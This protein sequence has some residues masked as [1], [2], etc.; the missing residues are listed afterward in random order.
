MKAY[1]INL[2]KIVLVLESFI[3]FPLTNVISINVGIVGAGSEP[4]LQSNRKCKREIRERD[5]VRKAR[6][7]TPF[8]LGL[9]LMLLFL[10]LKSMKLIDF[11][12][13]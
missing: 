13:K 11:K 5:T 3:Q 8:L 12:R 10:D 2:I 7:Q 1:I 6:A 4:E 9:T